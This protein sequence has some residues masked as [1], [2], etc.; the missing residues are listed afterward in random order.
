MRNRIS[1]E[2]EKACMTSNIFFHKSA[3]NSYFFSFYK[4]F[5]CMSNVALYGK[6]YYTSY[7]CW[8]F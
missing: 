3:S 5:F 6:K 8:T 2:T 1:K 7:N 4:N